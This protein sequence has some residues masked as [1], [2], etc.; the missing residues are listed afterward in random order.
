MK[1]HTE[2]TV[3]VLPLCDLC[4][5]RGITRPATVD[6]KTT[7]G[8]WAHMCDA[9]YDVYGVGLGLGQGQRMVTP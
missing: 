6:G 9:H 3:T 7:M 2:V 4:T 8:P 5:E 1:N